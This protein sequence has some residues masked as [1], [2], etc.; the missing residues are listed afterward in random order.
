MRDQA[1]EQ[2]R[3]IRA[4]LRGLETLEVLN[5]QDGLTVTEVAARTSLPRTTAY[6]ILE[7]LC[8]G[9]FARR[10]VADDRYRPME[11]V[12]SLANGYHDDSWV[13]DTAA[14]VLT[15]LCRDILWPL[16]LSTVTDEGQVRVRLVTDHLSPLV[17]A[18][19]TPGQT[20]SLSASPSGLMFLACLSEAERKRALDEEGAEAEVASGALD[21]AAQAADCGYALDMRPVHGEAGL[22]LPVRD[23]DGQLRAVVCMRFIRSALTRDTA[24]EN[25]L[26]SLKDAVA[27]VETALHTSPSGRGLPAHAAAAV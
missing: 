10:D 24:I 4:L 8:L 6:R 16:M 11:R 25:F 14:P 27:Q 3:P 21:A 20:L 12:C 2:F 22:A 26:P 5:A 9:G 1:A 13:H 18:R 19:Y 7:T 15:A 23:R 17:L